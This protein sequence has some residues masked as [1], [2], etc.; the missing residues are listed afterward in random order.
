VLELLDPIPPGWPRDRLMAELERRIETATG[1]LLR[2]GISGLEIRAKI[3]SL[4]RDA[5][6]EQPRN[7]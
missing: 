7:S 4:C 2:E 6:T 1:A 3:P 5:P